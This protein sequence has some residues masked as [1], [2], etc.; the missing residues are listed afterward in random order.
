MLDSDVIGKQM[1]A[2]RRRVLIALKKSG[3]LT[4]DE[5]A[6]AL[7]ISAVAVRRHLSNLERDH[8]VTHREVQRGMGRP[9]FIYELTPEAVILF[10]RTYDQMATYVIESVRD[11]YGNEAVRAIFKKRTEELAEVYGPAMAGKSLPD[12]LQTLVHMREQEGYMPTLEHGEDGVF[13]LREAHCP[14]I[15]VAET[16]GE[17][18]AHEQALFVELLDADVIRQ[19]HV[20]HGDQVCSF[21]VRPRRAGDYGR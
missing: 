15:S 4:A 20:L 1:P 11:L 13:I 14:I 18:C 16:C 8:L 21:A 19:E 9:S 17:A 5:L 7:G 6:Q 3:G 10:P 12:R 2:T